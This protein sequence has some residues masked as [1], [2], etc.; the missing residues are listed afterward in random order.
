ML[1]LKVRVPRIKEATALGAAIAAGYGCG[2]YPDMASAAES[3]V[4]WDAEYLPD[5]GA[6]AVYEDLYGRWRK[7]YA[8][9]LALADEG[10]TDHMW[11]APGL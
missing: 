5:E 8:R 4:R 11:A 6:H 10:L 2:I 7:V 3:L 1:G 9:S